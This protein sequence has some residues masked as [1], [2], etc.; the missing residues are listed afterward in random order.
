MRKLQF[1]AGNQL[2]LLFCGDEYFSALIAEIDAAV[3]EIYL[4]TYIFADD[5][6][7]VAV[8]QALIRAAQRGASVR[9]IIDWLG[10]GGKQAEL[11]AAHF[12]RQG[13]ECRIFNP[14][15]KRGL[16]RTHRKI[17]VVDQRCA[18]IGGLNIIDDLTADDGSGQVLAFPRWDFAVHLLGPLVLHIDVEVRA[19]W[20]RHGHLNLKSRFQLL[21]QLREDMSSHSH[22]A[23]LASYVVRDNLRNRATIQRA[24]LQALGLA[25]KRAILANPYFAPGRKLRN[26][27]ISAASRGV[28]VTLLIGVGQFKLQD[29]VTHSFYPK[30]LKH[31]VKIVEYRKTQLHAKVAVIDHD[32]VTVGSSNFDGLSLFLNHEANIV[33]RDQEFAEQLIAHLEQGIADGVSVDAADYANQPWYK[34]AWYGTAYLIYRFLMR[35]ATFGSYTS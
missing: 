31:G 19:Q 2:R 33:I 6:T 7:A 35:V 26:A 27:L 21:R 16:A 1:V 8:Q 11:L 9:V 20:L 4:E 14:W 29:A 10:S 12:I 23:V 18:L 32:W 30:L 13:V 17:C 15:F 28:D 34:R 5:V 24:Y 22:Q 3:K 25:R